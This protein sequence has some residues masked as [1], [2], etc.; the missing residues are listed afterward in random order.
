M[1]VAATARLSAAQILRVVSR[2]REKEGGKRVN[3]A[4]RAVCS[5][6]CDER[7]K[8]N[9]ERIVSAPG[10]TD[11]QP[12]AMVIEITNASVAYATVL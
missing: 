10:D 9:Q 3:T 1:H 8:K 11:V 6:G 7:Q 4:G 12:D 2:W 5:A